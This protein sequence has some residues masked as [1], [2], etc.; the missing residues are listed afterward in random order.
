[1]YV[2]YWERRPECTGASTLVDAKAR[3]WSL[4]AF[5]LGILVGPASGAVYSDQ[6]APLGSWFVSDSALKTVYPKLSV[7]P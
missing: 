3:S 1:M 6:S 5:P 7:C 2:S 4:P